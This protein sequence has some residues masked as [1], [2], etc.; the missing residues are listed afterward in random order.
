MEV[1]YYSFSPSR[2]DKKWE[3]NEGVERI[4]EMKRIYKLD[5]TPMNEELQEEMFGQIMIDDE[6]LGGVVPLDFPGAIIIEESHLEFYCLDALVKAYGLTVKDEVPTKEEWI[7]LY[8][9]LNGEKSRKAISILSQEVDMEETEA[10]EV[11]ISYLD[12]VRP[13]VQDLKQTPDSVFIRDYHDGSNI[14]PEESD[15]LLKERA[16]KLLEKIVSSV[17]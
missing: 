17:N 12:E 14:S 4:S 11:L 5:S 16:P 1:A 9:E 8:S 6:E 10:E 2:S 3:G 13:V 7:R 15:K